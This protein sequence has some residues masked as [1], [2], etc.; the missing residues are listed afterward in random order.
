MGEGTDKERPSGE[1]KCQYHPD[2]DSTQ[3]CSICNRPLCASCAH[4]VKD[5][6]YCPT[7]LTEGIGSIRRTGRPEGRVCWPS[8]A[9]FSALVPGIGAV[10]NRQYLKAWTHFAVLASLLMM[11]NL[12]SGLFILVAFS[13]YVFTILDAY[14]S[15]QALLRQRL[16]RPGPAEDEQMNAP[17][18]GTMLIGIGLVFLLYNLDL[19]RLQWFAEFWPLSLVALG[20]FLIYE[21]FAQRSDPAGSR[22]SPD[23][24]RPDAVPAESASE[25]GDNAPFQE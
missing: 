18:W 21:H 25:K 15:A 7:C 2:R 5:K 17:V 13:F 19:I 22:T 20:L 10:Y 3:Q 6:R 11:A 14:R 24:S 8:R 9:A 1:M 16:N 4:T 23:L 12:A